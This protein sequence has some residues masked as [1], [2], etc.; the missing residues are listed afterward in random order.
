MIVCCVYIAAMAKQART[1]AHQASNLQRLSNLGRRPPLSDAATREATC[2][3][4]PGEEVNF[5]ETPTLEA[6]CDLIVWSQIS[7]VFCYE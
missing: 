4:V 5:L 6:M 2:D 7:C 3:Q 1:Y